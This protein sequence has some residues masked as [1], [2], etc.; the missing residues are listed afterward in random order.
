MSVF[1]APLQYL[2]GRL[3]P[4]F[5]GVLVAVLT[6]MAAQFVAQHYGTPA[7]LLA[8]LFG[9]ALNFLSEPEKTAVGIS[10][11][12]RNILRFGVAILGARV[13]LEMLTSLGWIFIS[14]LLAGTIAT[15]LFGV[16]LARVIGQGPRF[17]ILTAGA[18]AI[19]GASAAMAIAAVLPKDS[20]S[21][22]NLLFTVLGVTVLST[23]AMILY[24]ILTTYLGFDDITAGAF[25]GATVHDVAQVV[26][27]GFS[28]SDTAGET[29]TI[30][31]LIRVS[32]LAPVVILIALFW[33]QPE[34]SESG[35]QPPLIPGF[36]LGFLVLAALNS[37]GVIPETIQA[38]LASLSGWALL[39][40]IAA[41][42]MK[43]EIRSVLQL[44]AMPILLITAETL[45]LAGVMLVAIGYVG[46]L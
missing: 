1:R 33:R 44:G 17:A 21:E 35:A 19:C 4:L 40:A 22:R 12:A 27:A 45:F 26:G 8:L 3:T 11:S 6:A 46:V 25:I 24:P 14:I 29:S 38:A 16:F 5:P 37:F 23:V 30:V 39:T 10:F 13:S 31:K 9:I 2:E 18:V 20:R 15:I 32:F 28:I 7:M 41:V 43:T 36:V 34:Q 42:G